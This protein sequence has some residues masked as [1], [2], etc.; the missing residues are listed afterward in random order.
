MR[1]S[2]IALFYFCFAVTCSP[3]FS[4]DVPDYGKIWKIWG[5]EGQAAYLYGFVDG[6]GR[7]MQATMLQI[8][9]SNQRGDK[10]PD[11]FY[12]SI[13][14]KTATLY[15]G[16]KLIDIMTNF[17]KDP[18][19]SYIWFDDMV[20]IARDSLSGK[21]IT[22]TILE[23]RKSAIANHELNKKKQTK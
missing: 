23:A 22:A 10:I 11:D 19:N 13:R 7:A 18:A 9:A 3:A 12:E 16:D 5:K 20:Y 2:T 15:D 1:K 8:I 14:I 4:D 17:Y 21:D 6:G